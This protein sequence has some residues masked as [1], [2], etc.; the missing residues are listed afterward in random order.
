MSRTW[1]QFLM[2][3]QPQIG[4]LALMKTAYL[5]DYDWS[6]LHTFATIEL[7]KNAHL[8]DYHCTPLRLLTFSRLHTFATLNAHLCDYD[9]TPLR[10]RMHT[11]ATMNAH[12]CEY[13]LSHDCT[14]L[15][16]IELITTA[17]LMTA[18]LYDL[19][20][21]SRLHTFAT[22]LRTL[23]RIWVTHLG[24]HMRYPGVARHTKCGMTFSLV[25]HDSPALIERPPPPRGGF[26]CTIF[27]H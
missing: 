24:L 20:N 19:L 9:C 11:F 16:F 25:W 18:H 4:Y 15:R 8:L 5:C 12:L 22:T 10:L 13:W 27:P 23:S 3:P 2:R 17:H 26:L 1:P 14:S 6:K 21:W 7:I